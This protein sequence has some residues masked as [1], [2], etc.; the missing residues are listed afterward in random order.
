MSMIPYK[1]RKWIDKDKLD[2]FA[3]LF[4]RHPAVIDLLKEIM[5]TIEGLGNI[6]VR[7]YYYLSR[8]EHPTIIDFLKENPDKINWEYL[9]M[10]PNA[11]DL[12]K[13]NQDKIAW[14]RLSLEPNIFEIDYELMK[15][16]KEQVNHEII[17]FVF[18]P[19][20]LNKFNSLGFECGYD[21][22]ED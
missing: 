20:N 3:L 10:N 13:E 22:D 15:R 12:L 6:D 7:F 17:K 4:N 11:I 1:L 21:S 9:S 19:E 14:D 2:K 8:N 16:N 5:G 18:R